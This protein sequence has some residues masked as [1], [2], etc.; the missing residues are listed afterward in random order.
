MTKK[1]NAEQLIA[2]ERLAGREYTLAGTPRKKPRSDKENQKLGIDDDHIT[3]LY[4]DI[5]G[6]RSAKLNRI[7]RKVFHRS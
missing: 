6:I 5:D 2:M 1:L 7:L 4:G 3:H